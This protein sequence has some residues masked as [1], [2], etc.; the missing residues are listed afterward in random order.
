M[1]IVVGSSRSFMYR[2]VPIGRGTARLVSA[3]PEGTDTVFVKSRSEA[4]E[5]IK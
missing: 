3:K 2:T 5:S 1:L 4:I